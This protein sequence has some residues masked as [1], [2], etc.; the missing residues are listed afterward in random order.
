MWYS[1]LGSHAVGSDLW[2]GAQVP[3]RASICGSR[4]VS[5]RACPLHWVPPG[6]L[7]PL[8]PTPLPP[9]HCGEVSLIC[10][11]RLPHTVLIPRC[12]ASGCGAGLAGGRSWAEQPPP[13]PH[14][15]G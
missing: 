12:L 6:L 7:A 4:A 11:V 3:R 14:P 1:I 2:G 13:H 5:P 15:G 9:V 8:L 10:G